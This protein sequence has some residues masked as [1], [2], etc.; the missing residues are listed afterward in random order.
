MSLL[1]EFQA[2]GEEIN[3]CVVK[4][5]CSHNILILSCSFKE[6]DILTSIVFFFHTLK[7]NSYQQRFGYFFCVQKKTDIYTSL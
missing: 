5:E 2:S 7:V 3:I 1:M 4:G 6:E